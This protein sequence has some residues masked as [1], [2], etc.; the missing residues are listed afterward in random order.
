[1]TGVDS[2]LAWMRDNASWVFS[3]VG[4]AIGLA[5]FKWLGALRKRLSTNTV[6]I[7]GPA[8]G[9]H[10]LRECRV[11]GSV[12]PKSAHVCVVVHPRETGEYWPQGSARVRGDGS[13]EASVFIGSNATDQV[14][15]EF[16][17]MAVANPAHI[18]DGTPFLDSWP[19]GQAKS[20]IVRVRRT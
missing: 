1:M 18:L 9:A 17:L 3:G 14:G 5:I 15:R 2:I 7:L 16:E 8:P 6:S 13:F 20:A 10:V 11:V 12:R 4:V 19:E